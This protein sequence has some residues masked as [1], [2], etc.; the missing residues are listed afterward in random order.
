MTLYSKTRSLSSALTAHEQRR[1][2]EA[3]R[4]G[5]K[6]IAAAVMLGGAAMTITG[7]ATHSRSKS[8]ATEGDTLRIGVIGSNNTPGGPE[9]WAA[10]HGLLLPSLKSQG[11]RKIQFVSFTGGPYLNE[12]LAAG[13]L[14]VGIYGDTP[15]IVGHSAGLPTRLINQN[16]VGMNAWLIVRQ[17]GPK[18]VADLK[19][20]TIGTGRGSYMARY[21]EGLLTG[22]GIRKDVKVA[23]INTQEGEAAVKRGDLAAFTGSGPLE[24]QRGFRVLDEAARH[25]GLE[26][27]TVTVVTQSY[28]DSHPSFPAE[29]NKARAAW[30]DDLSSHQDDYFQETASHAGVPPAIYKQINPLQYYVKEPITQRGLALLNGTKD[31]LV[32]QRFARK[33]FAVDSWL[34]SPAPGVHTASRKS[35]GQ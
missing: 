25:P 35:E 18:T 23:N 34:A 21:V 28:L 8:A 24:V 14:D 27:T 17:D 26:G 16:A 11:V 20:K 2:I 33:D 4:S 31:F 19:G 6:M 12:A 29:W 30:I 7:C 10:R 22:A 15:A 3:R 9:G 5:R 13:A 1:A 32:Q